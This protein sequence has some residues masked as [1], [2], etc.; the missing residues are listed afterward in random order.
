MIGTVCN[1]IIKQFPPMFNI[2]PRMTVSGVVSRVLSVCFPSQCLFTKHLCSFHRAPL[3]SVSLCSVHSP[4]AATSF[5]SVHDKRASGHRTSASHS[6][7]SWPVTGTMP[8]LR[9]R[10]TS[11]APDVFPKRVTRR[12]KK[13]ETEHQSHVS[14]TLA[15]MQYRHCSHV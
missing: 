10:S 5:R 12:T 13:K 2:S 11:A 1:S 3:R 6:W 9:R 14:F 4:T 7:S 15:K 8:L